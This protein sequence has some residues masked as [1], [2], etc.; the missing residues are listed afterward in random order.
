MAIIKIID[1]DQLYLYMNGKLTY[2]RWLKTGQSFVFNNWAY[3]KYTYVSISERD[4]KLISKKVD[5]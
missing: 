1:Q 5:S 2:K 3:D 4:G